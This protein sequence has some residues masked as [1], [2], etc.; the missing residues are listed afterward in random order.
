MP[1]GSGFFITRS[2]HILTAA[3]VVRDCSEVTVQSVEIPEITLAEIIR[4]EG[5][6][7]DLALLKVGSFDRQPAKFPPRTGDEIQLGADVMAVGYPQPGTLVPILDAEPIVTRGNVSSVIGAL[8][9]V[10]DSNRF[11]FTAPIQGGNSGGP[12][13]D[14][15]GNVIGLAASTIYSFGLLRLDP[16]RIRAPDGTSRMDYVARER[17]AQNVNY[18]VSLGAVRRFLDDYLGEEEVE[19]NTEKGKI[20]PIEIAKAAREFTVMID[21]WLPPRQ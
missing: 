2:G 15:A 12:I 9:G 13:L 8:S 6:P 4:M 3:H 10:K 1:H 20:G 19:E 5:D 16:L 18:A 21:C 17:F 11:Q 7:V 14:D